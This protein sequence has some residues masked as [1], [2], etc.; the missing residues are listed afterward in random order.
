[1]IELEYHSHYTDLRRSQILGICFTFY[2]TFE[3]CIEILT[4]S[5]CICSNVSCVHTTK[6]IKGKKYTLF[7]SVFTVLISVTTES[8]PILQCN[9]CMN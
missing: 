6:I 2:S 9:T 4:D 1:M 5:A 8:V 7:N 3:L